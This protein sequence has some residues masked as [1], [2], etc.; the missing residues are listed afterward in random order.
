M[1]GSVCEWIHLAYDPYVVFFLPKIVH[2]KTYFVES[3]MFIAELQASSL[4]N[5]SFSSL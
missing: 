3:K 1:C 4:G 2:K 5:W